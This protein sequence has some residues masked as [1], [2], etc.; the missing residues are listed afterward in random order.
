MEKPLAIMFVGKT[1]SGKTSVARVLAIKLKYVVLDTD[2]LATFIRHNYPEILDFEREHR[3]FFDK[4]DFQPSLRLLLQ[5]TVFKY[6]ANAGLGVILS[7]GHS[8]QNIRNYQ[9][10]VAKELDLELVYV[11]FRISDDALLERVASSAKDTSVMVKS[12]SWPEVLARQSGIFCYAEPSESDY[13]LD[14]DASQS[15]EQIT[16]SILNFLIGKKLVVI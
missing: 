2:D 15:I 6:A 5:T 14:V 13:L 12:R 8:N 9:K 1:H 16:Q 10:K 4:E 3:S 7:N 11:N